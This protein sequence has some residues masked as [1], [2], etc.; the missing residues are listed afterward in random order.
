MPTGSPR[1]GAPEGPQTPEASPPPRQ[2]RRS[3]QQRREE[4]RARLLDVTIQSLLDVGYAATT[5]RRVAELAGVSQGAQNYHFPYRVELVGAAIE[6]LAERRIADLRERARSLPAD[7][8]KRA[9]LM[10]DLIWADFS[11]DLFTVFVKV[12]IAAA[13]EPELHARLVPVERELARSVSELVREL[14]GDLVGQPSLQRRLGLVLDALR[15]RALTA[16]FEPR[17]GP[18]RD[19]W[20]DLRQTL[21]ELVLAPTPDRDQLPPDQA[22]TT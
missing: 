5:T 18:V 6:E 4:T 14:A 10:L 16:S 15:G 7:P 22:N 12:W 13:E 11:S 2:V 20:P 21:L 3:Q 8:G 9:A 19:S 1:I 17:S